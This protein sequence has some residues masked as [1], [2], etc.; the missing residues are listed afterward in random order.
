G[1]RGHRQCPVQ[2][3]GDDAASG[4][5][6]RG[7]AG[8]R[9]RAPPV[10]EHP[11]GGGVIAALLGLLLAVPADARLTLHVGAHQIERIAPDFEL[12]ETEGPLRAELLPSGNELLLEPAGPGIA[13][14]F[15]F[16]RRE[17]QV[18]EVAIDASFPAPAPPPSCAAVK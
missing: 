17:V 13:R 4:A 8:R 11:R 16:A 14:A 5:A 15:L 18:I 10:R 2:R 9:G 7:R 12:V 1:H 6:L 3:A